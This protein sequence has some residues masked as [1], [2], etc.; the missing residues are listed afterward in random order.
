MSY[1]IRIK[2]NLNDLRFQDGVWELNSSEMPEVHAIHEEGS[3]QHLFREH[4]SRS[5]SPAVRYR[6][7]VFSRHIRVMERGLEVFG[8]GGVTVMFQLTYFEGVK[9]P[10][11]RAAFSVCSLSD[12]FYKNHGN[13]NAF[14]SMNEGNAIEFVSNGAS[15]V[16][17]IDDLI[18][19]RMETLPKNIQNGLLKLYREL[20]EFSGDAAYLRLD[21]TYQPYY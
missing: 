21:T 16:D 10:T 2:G 9:F 1:K 20:D 13:R 11:V 15:L 5:R 4:C 3:L 12:V 18:H 19:Y 14:R 8:R 6:T 7:N 17:Q